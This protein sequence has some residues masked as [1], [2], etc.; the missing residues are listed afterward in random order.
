MVYPFHNHA[1]GEVAAK[2]QRSVKRKENVKF[3]LV[4]AISRTFT[5]KETSNHL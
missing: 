4:P 2:R 5:L 3:V 1:C